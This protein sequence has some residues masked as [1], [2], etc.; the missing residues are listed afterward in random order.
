VTHLRA[1]DHDLV[2]PGAYLA[3]AVTSLVLSL[4]SP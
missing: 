1:H 2:F 3:L 4:A